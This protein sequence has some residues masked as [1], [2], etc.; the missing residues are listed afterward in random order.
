MVVRSLT[1]SP[2]RLKDTPE[3]QLDTETSKNNKSVLCNTS[4]K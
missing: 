1:E 2:V 3:I 4:T